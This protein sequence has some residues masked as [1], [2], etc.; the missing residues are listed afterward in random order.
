MREILNGGN[1]G[2]HLHREYE[3]LR[4]P[5]ALTNRTQWSDLWE[6]DP[7]QGYPGKHPCEKPIALMEHMVETSTR[8]GDLVVDSFVGSGSTGVACIRL[9]RR[10]IG[11]ENDERWFKTACK[12]IDEAQC[13]GRLFD[14]PKPRAVQ[15]DLLSA[16]EPR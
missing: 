4:R 2:K 16:Q 3:D 14:P 7:V 12:R 6:F 10:F 8:K 15:M 9:G 5:F 11:I 13:Q 1:S